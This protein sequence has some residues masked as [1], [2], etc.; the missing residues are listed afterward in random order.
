MSIWGKILGGTAGLLVGGPLG[1]LAGA[2]A[3]HAAGLYCGDLDETPGDPE[4]LKQRM[5][6]PIG[7]VVLGAKMA[8]ADGV[9]T[10]HEVTAF[11]RVFSIPPEEMKNVAW[12]CD[13]AKR[14]AAGFEPYA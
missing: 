6:F 4:I 3:G 11:K 14:D 9:V 10:R 13:R 12:L 7:S 8:Q 5:T 1:A 2:A